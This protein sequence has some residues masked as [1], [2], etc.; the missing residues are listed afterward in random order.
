MNYR[1]SLWRGAAFGLALIGANATADLHAQAV[2]Q[3]IP[4]TTDA[5]RLGEQMRAL[6][7]N[8]NDLAALL[9]RSLPAQKRSI[10]AMPG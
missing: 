2:V 6:A 7:V 10:R 9:R 5:D 1:P 3:P 4:G 8:P